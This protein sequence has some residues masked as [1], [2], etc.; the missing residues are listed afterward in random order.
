MSIKNPS[1]LGEYAA[2]L[3]YA[4]PDILSLARGVDQTDPIPDPIA[5]HPII[6]GFL[7]GF[8]RTMV[9]VAALRL[10]LDESQALVT[11]RAIANVMNRFARWSDLRD[12]LEKFSTIHLMSSCAIRV[13]HSVSASGLNFW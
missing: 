7:N 6:L 11:Y 12:R 13:R 4:F 1:E 3:T 10:N 8:G 9:R 5:F 2:D